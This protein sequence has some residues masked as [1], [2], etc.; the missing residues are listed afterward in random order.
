MSDEPSHQPQRSYVRRTGRITRG[1]ARALRNHWI[2]YGLSDDNM[3][4]LQK[5]FCR[6]APCF[7]E[8]GFG[9]GVG[10]ATLAEQHPEHDF[11]GIE[12]HEAG[13]GRL[14]SLLARRSIANVRILRGDAVML[15]RECFEAASL[16]GVL[17]YF[18]DPWPK[19]RHHK[20]RLVQPAWV[21]LMAVKL[22]VGGQFK[23]ATDW[24]DYAHHML[25][26]IET[27]GQFR[28]QAG[29]GQFMPDRGARIKTKF[30]QR[31]ER[32]G[33]GIYDL[34]FERV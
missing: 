29:P 16:A 22:A 18:P 7:V 27:Q 32:L 28:N 11:I 10:L 21:E 19:K 26:V 12:V 23:L 17:L 1:Q 4:N 2:T 3:L 30:E 13:I 9:M 34:C 25:S 15:L 14:L 20:R 8:V 24:E 31:G 5:I 33:H 6:R